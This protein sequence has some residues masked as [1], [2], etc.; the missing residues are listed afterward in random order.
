AGGVPRAQGRRVRQGRV[1]H[2]GSAGARWSHHRNHER[3]KRGSAAPGGPSA[4]RARRGAAALAALDRYPASAVGLSHRRAAGVRRRSPPQPG[5]ERDG[6]M[7]IQRWV[8]RLAALVLLSI[9]G[10]GEPPGSYAVP[11]DAVVGDGL[12]VA[13]G[14][15]RDAKVGDWRIE[16]DGDRVWVGDPLRQ[17]IAQNMTVDQMNLHTGDQIFVP[18][19]RHDPEGTWRIIGILVTLPAAIYGI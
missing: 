18:R 11:G 15:T 4:V 16:R 5:E 12:M 7:M 17:A 2:A 3:G 10:E 19:E 13:G 14:P 8:V 1:E 6:G 9:L